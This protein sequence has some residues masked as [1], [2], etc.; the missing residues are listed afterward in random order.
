MFEGKR[1]G[2]LLCFSLAI[3]S[4]FLGKGFPLIGGPIFGIGLGILLAS[5]GGSY[6]NKFK[7]GATFSAKK[8]L[9]L[10]VIF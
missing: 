1:L 10:S 3:V 7:E 2:I 4:W 8:L 6:L 5:I 9:Q